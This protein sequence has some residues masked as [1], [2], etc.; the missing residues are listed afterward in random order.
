MIFLTSPPLPRPC[1][2]SFPNSIL[3][4][5]FFSCAFPLLRSIPSRPALLPI[6]H[7]SLL[8]SNTHVLFSSPFFV[9]YFFFCHFLT[10][11][12]PPHIQG[13]LPLTQRNSGPTQ[14]TQM[15]GP[16]VVVAAAVTAAV[17]VVVV[18]A[19]VVVVVV[20]VAAVVEAEMRVA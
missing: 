18:V 9:S 2:L 20:V 15:R 12:P 14:N 8:T 19:A 4:L 3:L 5:F 6:L 1:T 13:L 7:S 17:V 11:L 10:H 16:V